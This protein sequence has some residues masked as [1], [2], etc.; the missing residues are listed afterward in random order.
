MLQRV[1]SGKS[2]LSRSRPR[3]RMPRPT[4]ARSSSLSARALRPGWASAAR[5]LR[6]RVVHAGISGDTTSGGVTRLDA[7]IAYQS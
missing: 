1:Q 6:Y 5:G 2:P 4:S 3:R 7:V